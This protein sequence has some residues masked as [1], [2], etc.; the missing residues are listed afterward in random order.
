M[1]ESL[2][3]WSIPREAWAV[4]TRTRIGVC[5]IVLLA[6]VGVAWLFLRD[7]GPPVMGRFA[8]LDPNGY[9][10]LTLTNRQSATLF[11]FS[12]DATLFS[13]PTKPG[14]VGQG[15]IPGVLLKPKGETQLLARPD[16]LARTVELECWPIRSQFRRELEARFG[17]L[18]NK[19]GIARSRFVFTVDLSA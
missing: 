7:E 19:L 17:A 9:T 15:I 16:S 13:A 18:L 5:S 10:I 14:P 8:G 11:C 12:H 2:A 6:A 1:A 4:T 3:G